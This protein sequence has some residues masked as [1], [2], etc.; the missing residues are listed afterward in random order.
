MAVRAGTLSLLLRNDSLAER[1]AFLSL[2]DR[3]KRIGLRQ[4]SFENLNLFEYPGVSA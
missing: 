2:A 3:A 1:S 4:D